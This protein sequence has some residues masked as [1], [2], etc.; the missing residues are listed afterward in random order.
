MVARAK[1]VTSRLLARLRGS[2]SLAVTLAAA[3]AIALAAI[4]LIL[5]ARTQGADTM[6][7]GEVLGWMRELKEIDA[8]W[9][10]E[11]L[12]TRNDFAPPAPVDYTP[13]VNR[14][15][16][17]LTAAA[18]ETGS[19]VLKRSM[20]DLTAAFLQKADLIEKFRNANAATKQALTRV[21]AADVEIAG[22]V[23]GSWQDF[24]DRDRLVAAENAVTLLLAEAQRYYY[25]PGE[26]QRKS[27]ETVAADL[28]EAA[29]QL[30]AA[31]RDGL[32]RLDANVQQLLGA[33]PIEEKL[34]DRL[35][36]IT[37]GPRVTSV[38]GA[39]ALERDSV[40]TWR[41]RYRVYLVYFSAAV[42]V[43]VA[44]LA[45]R[46]IASYRRL[47]VANEALER[48][49]AGRTRELTE[50]AGRLQES[51]AQ[52]VLTERMSEL[53]QMVAGLAHE[54]AT[55]LA[56]VKGS[57]STSRG[58]LPGLSLA[59]AEVEKLITLLKGGRETPDALAR[60]LAVVQAHVA[61]LEQHQVMGELQRLAQ[62]GL[63]GVDQ[64]SEIVVSLRNFGRLDRGRMADFNLNEGVQSTL[65]I[66]RHEVK[67]HTVQ[68]DY[69]DIPT[70]T[71]SPSQINQVLLSL[72]NNAAQ[73]IE[74]ERGT[75]R[76]TTRREDE[77]HVAVEIED[78]GKG[79]P[80]DVLPR[81]FD[82]L[83]TTRDSGKGTGLGLSISR[84][85]VAQHGGSITVDS[86]VGIGTKFRVV[87]PLNPP[88]R[89]ELAA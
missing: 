15:R 11:I 88:P 12:R 75:I 63:Y 34:H 1:A 40:L 59:L 9:D 20:T 78:N 24:R 19:P 43:L 69:G 73:A 55:P 8:R 48:R 22:L 62:D 42:L 35:A 83:F 45:A 87:L 7:Q 79:I 39:Y 53:G 52:L 10:V 57:L 86:A 13:Q 37:A 54:I 18:D 3:A 74:S 67:R 44:Y 46:L 77:A 21:L 49:L 31:V 5:Y 17:A 70:I 56:Y 33:K 89:E 65:R 4:L 82:P 16:K 66:A 58:R 36:F 61:E 51:E 14:L 50:T 72:I 64:I 81:I 68:E 80:P 29:A 71:C 28:V 41:E 2:R 27:V 85:I 84:K 23:R 30:P 38:A 25:A 26:A 60:Q 32:A 6:R 76:L 47:D